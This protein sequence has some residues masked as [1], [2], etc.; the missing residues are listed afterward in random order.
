MTT[1]QLV[2]SKS[3]SQQLTDAGVEHD[4]QKIQGSEKK[5]M[6]DKFK[7][8]L[9]GYTNKQFRKDLKEVLTTERK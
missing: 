7:K 8:G 1:Q 4:K 5:A 9:V 2:T 6:D 3:V